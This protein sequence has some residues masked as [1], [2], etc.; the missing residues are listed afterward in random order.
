MSSA[1][2]PETGDA[3]PPVRLSRLD[4]QARVGILRNLNPVPRPPARRPA[5]TGRW[6]SLRSSRRP[7]ENRVEQAAQDYHCAA[8]QGQHALP[9]T[10]VQRSAD[11]QVQRIDIAGLMS[12]VNDVGV[13]PAVRV[14][15]G[16]SVRADGDSPPEPPKRRKRPHILTP[17]AW[18]DDTDEDDDALAAAFEVA[19]QE[20]DAQHPAP[21]APSSRRRLWIV[22]M[23]LLVACAILVLIPGRVTP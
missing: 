8:T 19:R 10:A 9:E 20:H 1:L 22:L 23:G 17:E 11:G 12:S 14:A 18:T 7:P 4:R 15:Y 21:P 13:N 16:A 2:P 6:P 5:L 3:A